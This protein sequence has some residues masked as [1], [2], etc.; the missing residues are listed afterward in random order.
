[1]PHIH[2][3]PFT[4]PP[5][6]RRRPFI[7]SL[8]LLVVVVGL[9]AALAMT[10]STVRRHWLDRWASGFGELSV[11]EQIER[12]SRIHALGDYG[13]E[14]LVQRIIAVDDRVATVAVELLR[15][16]QAA[17]V[18]RDHDSLAAAHH[19]LLRGL[20]EIVERVPPS[21]IGRVE[22]LLNQTIIE[23]VE[24]R[25]EVMQAAYRQ[26][27]ELLSRVN[28]SVDAE[29]LVAD[30]QD[31]RMPSLVPLPVVIARAAVRPVT[32][33]TADGS[34]DPVVAAQS[35]VSGIS[36]KQATRSLPRTY[37]NP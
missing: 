1:M 14:T 11:D 8:K 10:Q 2:D 17:W 15:E 23:C 12:L 22:Q 18:S 30:S 6:S 37:S 13:T 3:N 16:Q 28:G 33:E 32:I 20:A 31:S 9:S 24:Q 29:R 36:S 5:A 19:R 25:G 35:V 21:R 27:N 7:V 26:A 4:I 34:P